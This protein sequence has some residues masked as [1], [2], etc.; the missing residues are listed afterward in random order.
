MSTVLADVAEFSRAVI[1]HW[2]WLAGIPA[3]GIIA[4]T[5][6][7]NGKNI[8]I[9]YIITTWVICLVIAFFL[10]WQDEKNKKAEAEG[11]LD[12]RKRKRIICD[13]L[14][15]FLQETQVFRV[16]IEQCS[17]QVP[18]NVENWVRRVRDYL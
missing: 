1:K 11:A 16:H 12:N 3:S 6:H 13:H 17:H 18:A 10:T 2:W 14:A 9:N 5:L 4:I 8:P 15:S 7:L